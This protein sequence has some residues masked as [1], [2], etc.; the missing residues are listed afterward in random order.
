MPQAPVIAGNAT[1]WKI[2][3]EIFFSSS[4]FGQFT[5][6]PI[7]SK[8][9]WLIVQMDQPR[10]ILAVSARLT[11]YLAATGNIKVIREAT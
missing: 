8:N 1:A 4:N 10:M 2:P 11:E 3:F 9:L 6:I 7:Y 5:A